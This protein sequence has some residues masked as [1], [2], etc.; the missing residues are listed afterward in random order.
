MTANRDSSD[1]SPLRRAIESKS[2]QLNLTRLIK[3]R[4]KV[5]AIPME[6]LEAIMCEA[7][8]N[9]IL[10]GDFDPVLDHESLREQ[11][12]TELRR[13]IKD[14]QEGRETNRERRDREALLKQVDQL[15]EE[16]ARQQSELATEQN[17]TPEQVQAREVE[18]L[19]L[20]IQKLNSALGASEDALRR[21]AEAKAG[22]PGI[23]SIYNEIQ[24]LSN[25]DGKYQE[26]MEM[27]KVV[28]VNNLRLM[29]RDVTADDLQGVEDQFLIDIP[30]G[31]PAS[32]LPGARPAVPAADIGPPPSPKRDA[33]PTEKRKLLFRKPVEPTTEETSF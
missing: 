25:K 27:I 19:Q 32:R 13:L 11:T 1:T 3:E 6:V 15:K 28:F 14:H 18:K 29:K 9:I 4:K 26:K 24:G 10:D 30:E 17:M 22:D 23:A 7:I 31:M 33:G 8:A 21:L 12:K 2:R 20:R 5:R 16:L